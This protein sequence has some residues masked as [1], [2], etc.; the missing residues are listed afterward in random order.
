M[1]T[2]LKMQLALASMHSGQWFGFNGETS[3]ENLVILDSSKTKPTEA[4][5]NAKIQEMEDADTS[6]VNAKVSGNQKLLDL[7]LTQSEATALTGYTPPVAE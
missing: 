4:E 5:I 6:K 1:N 2:Q 3:Y 7:G